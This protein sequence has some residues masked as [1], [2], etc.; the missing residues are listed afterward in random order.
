MK[1]SEKIKLYRDEKLEISQKEASKL[2]HVSNVSLSRYEA[3]QRQPSIETLKRM[4]KYYQMTDAEFIA[5]F[6][7]SVPNRKEMVQLVEETNETRTKYYNQ[8]SL[9]VEELIGEE[10]F[11]LLLLHLKDLSLEERRS[12]LALLLKN[13]TI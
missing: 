10:D 3:D 9:L 13:L 11:R 7:D 2:L 4:R 6:D 8:F 1:L 12:Q 5:L